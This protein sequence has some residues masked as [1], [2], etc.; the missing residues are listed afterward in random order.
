MQDLR[1][2][3]GVNVLGFRVWGL[4]RASAIGLMFCTRTLAIPSTP[5]ETRLQKAS[6]SP[7]IKPYLNQIQDFGL[8]GLEQ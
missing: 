2:A 8:K 1:F 6:T 5:P 3:A 7:S 4:I